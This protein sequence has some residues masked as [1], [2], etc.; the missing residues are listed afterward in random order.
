MTAL[1]SLL[2][3]NLLRV[4]TY[5]VK[6]FASSVFAGDLRPHATTTPR[7]N[8]CFSL[9]KVV[10]SVSGYVVFFYSLETCKEVPP[11]LVSG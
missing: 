11:A 1:N 9:V 3:V 2:D 5:S 4:F 10:D 7:S 6:H 8:I